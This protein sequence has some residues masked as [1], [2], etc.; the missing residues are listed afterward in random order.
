MDNS[1]HRARLKFYASSDGRIA[2]RDEGEGDVIVLIHGVPT[3]SW[4]YSDIIEV[5][6]SA[7]HRVIAPDMLGFGYFEFGAF[8]VLDMLG[9]FDIMFFIYIS[10]VGYFECLI[11]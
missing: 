11:F 8:R 3:S 2:Y 1:E 7:G 5:L 6:V 9:F 10:S 4:V